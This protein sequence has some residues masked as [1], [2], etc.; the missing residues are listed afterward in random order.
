MYWTAS[1]PCTGGMN[2]LLALRLAVVRPRLVQRNG[3]YI[4]LAEGASTVSAVYRLAECDRSK[5]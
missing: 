3:H 1:E 5:C 4:L 2:D